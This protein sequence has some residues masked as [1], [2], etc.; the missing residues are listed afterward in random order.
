[1]YKVQRPQDEDLCY[2]SEHLRVG[3][4]HATVFPFW[5]FQIH[6][7]SQSCSLSLLSVSGFAYNRKWQ[8]EDLGHPHPNFSSFS[9]SYNFLISLRYKKN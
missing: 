6:I 5:I 4:K 3:F 2:S 9:I 7:L 8:A 1:M